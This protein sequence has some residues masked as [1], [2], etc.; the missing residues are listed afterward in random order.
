[1]EISYFIWTGFG[2]EFEFDYGVFARGTPFDF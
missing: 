2:Q 1:M